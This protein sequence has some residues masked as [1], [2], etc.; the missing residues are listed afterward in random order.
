MVTIL[1]ALRAARAV[2]AGQIAG[3]ASDRSQIP[4]LVRAARET[5]LRR[6]LYEFSSKRI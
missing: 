1:Q 4:I 2:D 3:E 6:V 5:A